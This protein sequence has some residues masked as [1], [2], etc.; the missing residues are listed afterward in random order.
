VLNNQA[1]TEEKEVEK[2]PQ[3]ITISE[4][5]SV[6]TTHEKSDREHIMKLNQSDE[7]QRNKLLLN[8]SH[9]SRQIDSGGGGD[10]LIKALN[11][12]LKGRFIKAPN[13][14]NGGPKKQAKSSDI[15]HHK[16]SNRTAK[17]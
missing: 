7:G 13:M 9:S 2:T 15:T 5:V 3:S 1:P 14:K 10:H 12:G 6:P 11:D 4:S 16:N 17:A 8:N